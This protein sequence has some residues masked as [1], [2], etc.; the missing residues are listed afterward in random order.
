M[1]I[2]MARFN[3]SILGITASAGAR[4]RYHRRVFS[5][6]NAISRQRGAE[7][8]C[9]IKYAKGLRD[10]LETACPMR[11][12]QASVAHSDVGFAESVRFICLSFC[13]RCVLWCDAPFRYAPQRL[14]ADGK[15]NGDNAASCGKPET[16]WTDGVAGQKKIF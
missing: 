9:S 4:L 10:T 15:H 11:V 7:C 3:Q 5:R 2:L 14:L 6:V 12:A 1:D 16:R 8:V 13:A